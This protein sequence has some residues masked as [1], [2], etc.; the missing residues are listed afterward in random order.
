[1]FFRRVTQHQQQSGSRDAKQDD[2]KRRKIAAKTHIVFAFRFSLF[3]HDEVK[4]R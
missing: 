4:T 1:V 3:F 2:A